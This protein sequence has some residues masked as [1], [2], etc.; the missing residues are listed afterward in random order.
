MAHSRVYG[1]KLCAGSLSP[2]D[3]VAP[4]HTQPFMPIDQIQTYL[5]RNKDFELLSIIK[6][7]N[8]EN[9]LYP[10]DILRRYTAVF[11]TLLKSGHGKYIELFRHKPSLRDSY[12]PL[13]V[14][15]PPP[16]FPNSSEERAL[17]VDFCREQ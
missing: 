17:L 4:R 11:C 15:N 1:G 16:G 12:L 5:S 8:L 7:L 6:E 2:R 13:S 3:L 14:K 10:K 9:D